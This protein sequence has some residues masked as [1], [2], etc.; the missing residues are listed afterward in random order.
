MHTPL[1]V[2]A[3]VSGL[4]FCDEAC[5]A[6]PDV[7]ALRAYAEG[8]GEPVPLQWALCAAEMPLA[9]GLLRH[10]VTALLD[11]LDALD[12][13]DRA[14]LRDGSGLWHALRRAPDWLLRPGE[15]DDRH[16]DVALLLERDES[17][18]GD[19]LALIE[20][21]H[22]VG[23]HEWQWAIG[24]C[25]AMQALERRWG[26]NLRELLVPVEDEHT[27]LDDP[28]PRWAGGRTPSLAPTPARPEDAGTQ[29]SDT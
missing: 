25:R 29:E 24:R 28:P 1:L 6:Y 18:G 2:E 16:A 10:A 20:A 26:L 8:G 27:T 19:W 13:A 11:L 12:A 17:H 22:R 15:P 14:A 9:R 5:E 23:S 3:L 4:V 7:E 21:L